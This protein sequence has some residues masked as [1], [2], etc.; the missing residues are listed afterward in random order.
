M[1]QTYRLRLSR[2]ALK[3]RVATRIPAQF[4]DGVGISI[5]KA[6]GVYTAD[7]DYS[8][9]GE[10]TAYDDSL[11]ATTYLAS[12]EST[13]DAFSR[14]S[15]TNIKADFAL[16][17]G[18]LYQP[19]DATLT[20]LA[21]LNST[22]GLVVETAADTFTKRTLTA[23]ALI[24]VT[25]GDGVSGNPTIAV[26]DAELVALGGL[27]SAADK[28]P[29]FTGSG[30][31]SLADFSAFARTLVDDASQ[32]AMRTTLGLT[33][34]TDV[35]AYDADLAALAAN[36]T[37]G[38]WAHTGAGTGA[39]RTL[40]APAAGFTITNP[41]GIAGNP[42]F[43]LADDLAALEGLAST[44]VARRTGAS[45][46]SVGA[47]IAL[48]ELATQSAYTIVGNFTGSSAVPTASTIPALTHKA[49][50]VG[51]DKIIISDSAASDAI[52]YSTLTEAIGAVASGVS[53]VNNVT[54]AVTYLAGMHNRLI[55]PSGEIWQRANSSGG[56]VT[57]GVYA[58]DRWY[59]LSQTAGNSASQTTNAENTTPYM[60][61]LAQ[62]N[63]AAQR[64]GIAQ[65]IE[66]KNCIDLRGQGVVLS[67]RVRMSASTTLRYAIIEWTGTA[68]TV[69][70]DFVL[71]WTNGT[72]T[73]GQ[74]FTTT[75]TTITA[76]GSTALTA[77]TLTSISLTGT[78]GSSANNIAVIF[79]TDSTQ[80]QNVTLEIGKAQ[81]EMGS[82]ATALAKRSIT[83]ELAL[84]QRYYYRRNSSAAN[85]VIAMQQS[86]A[87]TAFFGLILALPVTMMKVPTSAVSNVAHFSIN[88][89]SSTT[90]TVSTLSIASNSVNSLGSQS[91]T[92][93]GASLNVGGA[94]MLQ[95]NTTSGWIEADAEI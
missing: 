57:D 68:D 10:I 14:M 52:V 33:P 94:A 53:S 2:P 18:G 75:S 17:F 19:L 27:T 26:T 39:A 41:A 12:W 83:E 85:E 59:G 72:F 16:T 64:F 44:G 70:K 51:A 58:F 46:W 32:A 91:A 35:Q 77:N 40:T 34:G 38:L 61:K 65:V 81:L 67:A 47:A 95:F 49:A 62:A 89:P 88:N 9:L 43:V 66:S 29:Y 6:N 63:A 78:I 25:N 76:T 71:D 13:A 28:L 20:A 21:A 48:S 4:N 42:T 79:W 30:T 60:M 50:P 87:A 84:C 11:E 93:S 74:F 69:T 22:A 90:A 80:A 5:T 1:S 92:S 73:A 37:D 56:A 45:T 82:T 55:N 15:I 36:S 23:G 31:A 54:G 8:E 24:G 86:Y 7:L 3:L